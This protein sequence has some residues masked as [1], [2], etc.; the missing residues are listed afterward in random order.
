MGVFFSFYHVK[1]FTADRLVSLYALPHRALFSLYASNFK[2]Y[3]DSFYRVR[4]GP[5]CQDVMYYSDETPL[6]PFYWSSNP[7]LIKGPDADHLSSFEMETVAFLNSFD[8]LSTKELVKLE[9]NPN[10]VVEY[11]SKFYLAIFICLF[12]YNFWISY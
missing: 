9:T 7:R 3:Q 10:G 6:F 8:I 1:S 5:N 4:G 11:L 2:N 12:Q